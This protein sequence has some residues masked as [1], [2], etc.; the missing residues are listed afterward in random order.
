MTSFYK[1]SVCELLWNSYNTQQ[2]CSCVFWI[3][4][5]KCLN[6]YTVKT[7]GAIVRPALVKAVGVQ[8]CSTEHTAQTRAEAAGSGEWEVGA[9]LLTNVWSK[10]TK[11]QRMDKASASHMQ[12]VMISFHG[13]L[14]VSFFPKW[15]NWILFCKWRKCFVTFCQSNSATIK[16]S[17]GAIKRFSEEAFNKINK[18]AYCECVHITWLVINPMWATVF[19]GHSHHCQSSAAL[20]ISA[21]AQ[22]MHSPAL[23]PDAAL[24]LPKHFQAQLIC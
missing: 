20:Q 11:C 23:R 7:L 21:A 5:V 2:V 6:H 22:S 9:D 1:V 3:N 19:T 18:H 14:N 24:T 15:L 8:I 12:R 10:A 17:K 13:S 16:K 4:H